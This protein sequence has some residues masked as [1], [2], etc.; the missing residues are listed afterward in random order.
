MPI[1]EQENQ[2]ILTQLEVVAE[3]IGHE[4]KPY[5]NRVAQIADVLLGVKPA[6]HEFS[7]PYLELQVVGAAP[8]EEPL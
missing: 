8:V 1:S 7:L 4:M 6:A 5:F 2:D 3:H